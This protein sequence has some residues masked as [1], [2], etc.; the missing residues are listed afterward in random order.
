MAVVLSPF[1]LVTVEESLN[2]GMVSEW[3]DLYGIK[4][5]A[6]KTKTRTM[7][8]SRS[9]PMR[10]QSPPLT[11]GRTVLKES[12]DLHILG[13]TFD[14]MMTFDKHLRSVSR[15]ASERLGFL[16]MSWRVSRDRLLLLRFF[17]GLSCPFWST[18]LQCSACCRYTP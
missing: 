16:T 3:C 11:T 8:A 1:V 12:D 4:L 6:S 17:L 13:V 10:P 7:I 5:N 15:A 9:R 14:S 18:V 2:L